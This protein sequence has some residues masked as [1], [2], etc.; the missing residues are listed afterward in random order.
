VGPKSSGGPFLP[1]PAPSVRNLF[2]CSFSVRAGHPR[3][4]HARHPWRGARR[5]SA[6]RL[7]RGCPTRTEHL[8]LCCRTDG[9]GPRC[10][11]LRVRF[12]PRDLNLMDLKNVNSARPQSA[13]RIAC[14]G[15]SQIRF[16]R[17]GI[18]TP[19]S[20]RRIY[21]RLI[22]NDCHA[23]EKAKYVLSGESPCQGKVSLHFVS[24]VVESTEG[25]LKLTESSLRD[26]DARI[27]GA[28]GGHYSFFLRKQNE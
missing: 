14:G 10:S 25:F 16:A 28:A 9:A 13:L 18:K 3:S 8:D 19:T 23:S 27:Q 15:A 26:P 5:R 7:A 21:K 12:G 22:T 6:L 20:C 2:R 24:S 11:G 17:R 1:H 4:G